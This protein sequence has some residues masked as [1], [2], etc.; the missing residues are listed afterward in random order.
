MVS[1][2]ADV[3]LTTKPDGFQPPVACTLGADDVPARIAEWREVLADVTAREEILGG[4]RLVL[5][6]ESSVS[7]IAALAVAEQ[8]CCA[9]FSF[10]LTVDGRGVALEVTAPT[11]GE[12]VIA[13]LFGEPSG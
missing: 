6:D 5:S 4:L 11:D 7:R 13:E 1:L 12:E 2:M 8:E 9:F 10:A 3:R